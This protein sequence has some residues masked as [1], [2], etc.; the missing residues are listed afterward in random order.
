M[1]LKIGFTGTD[2]TGKSTVINKLAKLVSN[3]HTIK[4]L[5]IGDIAR[6]SPYPVIEQQS[7]ESSYWILK[8][9]ISSELTLQYETDVL[10]C[11]RTVLDIWVF[12]MLSAINGLISHQALYLFSQ[13][14]RAWLRTYKVVFY[15]VIDNSIPVNVNNVPNGNL[16]MREQFEELLLIGIETFKAETVFVKLP[17]TLEE[18]IALVRSA[19]NT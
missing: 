4:V 18:R 11:D 7:I 2:S 12:S 15:G 5:S 6:H 17:S 3:G 1:G 9:V 14:V 19:L 10:I 8:Q 13:E 16:K